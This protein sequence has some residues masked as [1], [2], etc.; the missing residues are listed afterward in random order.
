[1]KCGVLATLA[2]S[3]LFVLPAAAQTIVTAT[4][5]DPAGIPYAYGSVKAQL[6]MTGV[7]A[8]TGQPTVMVTNAQQC[9]SS[10]QGSAPCQIPFHGTVG[11]FS[12]NSAGAFTVVL[13]DNALV[14]PAGTQWLFTV[15]ETPGVPAP[16]GFASQSFSVP[17][18]ITGASQDISAT[19]NAVAPLLARF[20]GL[21]TFS[22]T[23]TG[24]CTAGQLAVDATTGQ[25]YT[26]SGGAWTLATISSGAGPPVGACT[27]NQVYLDTTAGTLYTCNGATWTP[28]NT[29]GGS[30]SY[31]ETG[32]DQLFTSSTSG[33]Q[34]T[35][36]GLYCIAIHP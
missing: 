20:A 3:L 9:A 17:I 12:T 27:G 34:L 31:S 1:M 4:V 35:Q 14:T 19:L 2:A 24:S 21:Q 16:F 33:T 7:A 22:G 11:P 29:G 25:L 8:V 28:A 23:P 13:Q 15:T 6:V 36:T 26:C 30:F 32:L 5:H 18:T 10:G